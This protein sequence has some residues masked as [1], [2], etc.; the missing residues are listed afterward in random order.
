MSA[1]VGFVGLGMMGRPMAANLLSAG[2]EVVV[3]NRSRGPVD[4][5]AELGATAADTVAAAARD[6][7]LVITMLPDSPDVAAVVAGPDG[8]L[9]RGRAGDAA[10]R[11]E[12]DLA[13]HRSG[14]RR[15]G[16]APRL[17]DA[18]RPGLRR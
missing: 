9:S 18:G 4:A 1:R 2:Y 16:A 8:L 14:A 13:D 11:H 3:A 15:G 7:D 17:L 12:H 6:V 10:D 5:L